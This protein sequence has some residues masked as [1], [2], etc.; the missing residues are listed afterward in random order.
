MTK[1]KSW[2]VV[3]LAA[4]LLI[5]IPL[6]ALAHGLGGRSDLPV[7]LGYAVAG[8]LTVLVLTFVALVRL[9]P[10][11]R[12]QEPPVLRPIRFPGWRLVAVA[13]RGLGISVL[14]V[15][16]ATGL[17]GADNS[18]RN[19]APVLMWVGFWLLVPFASAAVGDLYRLTN[20]WDLLV[21]GGSAPQRV[22]PPSLGV[23]PALVLFV[24]FVWIELIYPRAADPVAVAAVVLVF[25]LLMVLSADRWEGGLDGFDPFRTYNGLV[26]SLAP[27]QLSEETPQWRGWLRA[28]PLL[29]AR[30][31]LT[32]FVITTIAT[33]TYD[34]LSATGWYDRT[35]GSFGG[36]MT[37]SS[38]LLMATGSLLAVAYTGACWAAARQ[39]RGR[40][41]TSIVA[42]RFAH[43][44]VPIAF[45]Y[46]FAHY[47]TLVVFEGQLLLSTL[48][49][50]FGRGW[51]L[52][53]TTGRSVDFTL[54]S[55]Y[56]I[57][58]VQVAVIVVG[59]VA[60]VVLAHDRALLDFPT[61]TSVRSQYV[62]LALMVLLTTLGL[63]I[64][65]AS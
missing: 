15:L 20:P 12:M 62:M 16:V 50:P 47:F 61:D 2:V 35:F 44:L 11:P 19:P 64:L 14:V 34:G 4:G 36:S 26:S 23:W 30:P 60:G 22:W 24:A 51:N 45:A 38:L 55:P 13:L 27:I 63:V 46:A 59:H 28:L 33:V 18:V 39:A 65:S 43:T 49:D 42:Q 7:P 31:G 1:R 56:A 9:W 53:G 41:T 40:W 25:G 3:L 54:L 37:G 32:A 58:W 48:S 10:E 21:K 17:F 8:A 6:P 52:L 57:W 5:A 29:P